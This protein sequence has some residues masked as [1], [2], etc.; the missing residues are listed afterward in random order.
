MGEFDELEKKLRA[1]NFSRFSKQKDGSFQEL[2][3]MYAAA[4]SSSLRSIV[5]QSDDDCRLTDDELDFVAA[6]GQS[7][8]PDRHR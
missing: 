5:E 4:D 7:M 6:A 3:E 8:P 2:S 1:V